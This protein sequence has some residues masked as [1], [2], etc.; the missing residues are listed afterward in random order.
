MSVRLIKDKF[1]ESAVS[2]LPIVVIVFLVSL[3]PI[4]T[5]SM[6]ELKIFLICSIALIIGMTLFNIGAEL[7]MTP[8][9][10][11]AGTGLMK[12]KKLSLILL[13]ALFMGI[14]VTI[15]E[16]DLIVLSNQVKDVVNASTFVIS[17]AVGVGVFLVIALLR[18]VFNKELATLLLLFYML[19]FA[20][21]ALIEEVDK[22]ALIPLAF[23]S[24]G[25]TTG[26]ITVPFIMAFGVGIAATLG[27]KKGNE[28]SFGF[29][30]LCSAGPVLVVFISLIMS[31]GSVNY[32]LPDYSISGVLA[33]G[34]WKVILGEAINVF[35]ALG[36]IFAFFLLLNI[37]IIKLPIKKLLQIVIGL[38]ITF[39]GLV[40]FLTTASIGFLPMGFSL[41]SQIIKSNKMIAVGLCFIIGMTVVLAEPAIHVLINQVE[42]VT[43]GSVSKK[44]M[45]VALSI[46]VGTAIALAVVRIVLNFP[47]IFYLLPG[48]FI[49]LALSLFVPPLY[50][51]IAFDSGGVASG[52][53]TSTFIVPF[54]IGACVECTGADAVLELAFGVVALVAMIPLISIQT[55]GFKAVMS[56]IVK[57]KISM[58]RILRADDNQ[59]IYFE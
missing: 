11:Y 14:L 2:I 3:T 24:G 30:A 7:S 19:I 16:P 58:T 23:D 40:I 22:W 38:L 33:N 36:L 57:D 54:M 51:A 4:V 27:G 32:T 17:V 59:I 45:L 46:G 15:A 53:L 55:L 37:A 47:L 48:Y 20:L 29:V 52:P 18:A 21:T 1:K 56:K 6:V 34:L 31:H 10:D 12:T 25:V 49:S 35:R 44:S 28:N 13:V 5:I 43:G 9:G 50:T 26:P 8:M 42:S 39:A 41:G